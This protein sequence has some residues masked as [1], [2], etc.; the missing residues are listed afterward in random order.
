[1]KWPW[2]G[3]NAVERAK[4]VALSYRHLLVQVAGGDVFDPSVAL[5]AIDERWAELGAGWILP[6]DSPL[7]LDD[8][9]TD[10]E[11]AELFHL[12]PKQ[13]YN[14]GYRGH[15]AV[16]IFGGERKYR[17]GDVVDYERHRRLRRTPA[18]SSGQ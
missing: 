15:I 3:D 16:E 4:R 7:R 18:V 13:V 9:L 10:K 11:M 6:T 2:P 17:V 14:W 8:W 1:M 5:Q 12:T